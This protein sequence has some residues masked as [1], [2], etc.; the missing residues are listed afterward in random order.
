MLHKSSFSLNIIKSNNLRTNQLQVLSCLLHL[1]VTKIC[2][3]WNQTWNLVGWLVL[4]ESNLATRFGTNFNCH[5][6]LSPAGNLVQH[7]IQLKVHTK[8]LYTIRSIYL[9]LTVHHPFVNQISLTCDFLQNSTSKE[10]NTSVVLNYGQT[11][12]ASSFIYFW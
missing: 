3:E 10:G 11:N 2:L 4:L 7:R 9:K 6:G 12:S 8:I 1:T 5:P